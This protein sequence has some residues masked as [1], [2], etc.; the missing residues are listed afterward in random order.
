MGRSSRCE[1]DG[2]RRGFWTDA[3]DQILLDYVREHGEGRWEKLSRETGE[4]ASIL[5]TSFLV[6][7]HECL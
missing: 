4:L 1:K 5:R 7:T 2:L 6:T 3:E